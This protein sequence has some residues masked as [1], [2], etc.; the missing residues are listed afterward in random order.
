M[1]EKF[2]NVST[3]VAAEV[4][5]QLNRILNQMGLNEY[6]WLQ[7]MI[8]V[9]IRMMD[10]RHN[11]SAAMAKMIQMF[12]MVPGFK[13]A[14]SLVDANAEGKID[15]AVY[16]VNVKGK[17]GYKP[18]MIERT[19]FD[20]Q[21]NET[22]NVKSI[23]EC[24]IQRCA[25][26]SYMKLREHMQ[27]LECDSVFE[28]L[29]EMVDAYHLVRPEMEIQSLFDDLRTDGGKGYAYG[30]KTK[31]KQKRSP[32]SLAADQRIKQQTI[33]FDDDDR[34]TADMEVQ[35]WEGEH[36]QTEEPPIRPFDVE[37]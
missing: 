19:W 23:V 29:M 15:A 8:E 3:K 27:E 35:D 11:L 9:T 6:Q 32:D 21:W 5:E 2:E 36:R 33:V 22:H 37:W 7:L 17:K 25:P 12:R 26:D 14:A 10:D 24:V 1:K 34:E 13:D 30:Q 16:F 18:V 31:A 28:C 4:K 20:G